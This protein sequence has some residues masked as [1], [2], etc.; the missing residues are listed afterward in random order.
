[1]PKSRIMTSRKWLGDLLYDA[2]V[3]DEVPEKFEQLRQFLI[4]KVG[5]LIKK[6]AITQRLDAILLDEAQDYLPEEMRSCQEVC[7]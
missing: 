2:G 1:M 7:K 6:G 3:D 5:A 4:K